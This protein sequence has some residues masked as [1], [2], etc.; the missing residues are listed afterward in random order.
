MNDFDRLADLLEQM[1]A[2]IEMGTTLTGFYITVWGYTRGC[3]FNFDPSGH[4][5][6]FQE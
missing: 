5:V 3:S 2:N 6:D 1:G 4:F